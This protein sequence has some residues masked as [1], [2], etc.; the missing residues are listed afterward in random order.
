MR[1]G[2]LHVTYESG[3]IG[4]AKYPKK[5]RNAEITNEQSDKEWAEGGKQVEMRKG[6]EL[7]EL[8]DGRAVYK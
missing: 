4:S 5:G 6:S 2:T 8:L 7:S 3:M 1:S